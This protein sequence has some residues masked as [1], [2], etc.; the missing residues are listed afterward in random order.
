MRTIPRTRDAV[1]VT[2]ALVTVLA[3]T[4]LLYLWGLNASGWANAYYSAA[5]QAGSVNWLAMLFGALDAGN[6]ISID[7][8]PASV[9]VMALSV[10]V[11]GMSSWS[12][13]AP[14]ALMGV[15][16]VWLLYLTVR[17]SFGPIAALVAGIA[18]ALTPVAVLMFRFNNPDA[19]LVLLL[20]AAVYTTMRALET[21]ST[22]WLVVAGVVVGLAFLTKMLQ[23]FLIVPALA[24][25]YLLA[26][27]TTLRRRVWGVAV[28]GIAVVVSAGWYVALVEL[29]PADARPYVGGSQTNSLIEL[30]LGYNGL[31]RLTGD[32]IGRVGG[33]A[34]GAATGL[35]RLFQGETATEA[36]WLLPAAL[37][38]LG[39]LL[40]SRRRTP[41]TDPIRAQVLVWG[42]WLVGT[43]LV[44]SLMQG[45]FHDYYTVAL[46]P[47]IAALV[48]IGAGTVWRRRYRAGSVLAGAA[49]VGVSAL[50]AAILLWS[51]PSWMPW[52]AWVVIAAGILG[53]AALLLAAVNFG[54]TTQRIALVASLAVLVVSPA[55]AS[56]ATAAEPH[57]G[58]IPTAEPRAEIAPG[59][60]GGGFGFD[61]NRGGAL[62]PPARGFGGA[63]F[64]GGGGLGGLLDA[65]AAD[66]ELIDLLETDADQFRWAAA[67]TGA[68]NAA[69]L[70]L[71]TGTSVMSIG[72]FN[73][74]D[75]YPSLAEF[76]AYVAE[77]AIHYYAAGADATGF[78]GARGGS[79][80][81]AQIA[82]W[83]DANFSAISVGGVTV[84][85]LTTPAA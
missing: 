44:F 36:S 40:W 17:R 24:G 60:S 80:A 50:W 26:A 19:L 33:G 37:L 38:A 84:Y 5:A 3:G 21:A 58:A 27:P 75:S 46:A 82:E 1:W 52:L 65:G 57:T 71:S 11:F 8:T 18:L 62:S 49:T 55:A 20:V 69:G 73:G 59:G 13:L 63:G 79:D 10:R 54:R 83:V 39:G 68:N 31:G 9:W 12:V 56:F 72:G 2:P 15:G 14:Q 41:R 85:D 7:K 67:T 78:R 48:G 32:E 23:G 6:A 35:L 70:A 42:G 29:L 81:A 45:I 30:I 61:G 66:A 22:R 16:S 74:T 4:G 34:F 64:G 47:P 28:A 77:G 25:V 43:G 51:S 53:V 76:Q